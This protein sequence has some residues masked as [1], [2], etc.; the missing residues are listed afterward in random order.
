MS[1]SEKRFL[2]VQDMIDRLGV[3]RATLYRMIDE[4]EIPAPYRPQ[5]RSRKG[6]K[7]EGKPGTGRPRWLRVV[8][9]DY[10]RRVLKVSA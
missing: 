10:E 6:S 3:S 1:D 2:Y 8:V 7:N 5:V 4:G 9:E